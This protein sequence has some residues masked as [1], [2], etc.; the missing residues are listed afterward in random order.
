MSGLGFF[1]TATGGTDG[2]HMASGQNNRFLAVPFA[3]LA[4]L[5]D[6]DPICDSVER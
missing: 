2:C 1:A 6:S 4:R 3:I 5:N